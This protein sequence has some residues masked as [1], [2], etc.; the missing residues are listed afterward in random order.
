M[1]LISA[2]INVDTRPECE[3]QTGLFNG[4]VSRDFLT[5][6]IYN[7]KKFLEGFDTEIIVFCDE[8]EPIDETTLK[9]LRSITDCLV[10]RKHTHE[11]GFNNYNYLQA[12]MM[13]RG[14][15]I[16]HFDQDCVGFTSSKEPVNGL[17]SLLDKYDYVSYPSLWSPNAVDDPNYDYLWCSTRF[18]CCKR[19]TLDFT[20]IDKCLQDYDYMFTQYPASRKHHWLE[21]I[22]GLIAKYKGNGVYYPK[23]EYDKWVLFTWERYHKWT[24]RRLNELPYN[25][26]KDWVLQRGGIQYPN[27]VTC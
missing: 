14:T 6:T 27:N 7:V 24:L 13:A 26:V 11:E 17:I 18:Y 15:Y 3:S 1:P 21:H 25:E 12:L 23:I 2:I 9:Y 4:A 10:I 5:D 8:H 20:E 19:K 16:F 22:L